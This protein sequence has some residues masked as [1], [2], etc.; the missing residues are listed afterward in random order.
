MSAHGSRA[1]GRCSTPIRQEL[2]ACSGERPELAVAPAGGSGL[3]RRQPWL[4][5]VVRSG[6]LRDGLRSGASPVAGACQGSLEYLELIGCKAF[7]QMAGELK[8]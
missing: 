5:K 3:E 4:R 6:E 8:A 2:W 1:A 7:D